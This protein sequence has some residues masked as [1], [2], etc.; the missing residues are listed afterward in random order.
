MRNAT[1]LVIIPLTIAAWLRYLLGISDTGHPMP[2]SPD[3]LYSELSSLLSHVRFGEPATGR[4]ALKDILSNPTI[5][6]V[7]LY[8]CQLA[9]KIATMF[10]E[11]L[12]G[13]GAVQATLRKY[14][15]LHAKDD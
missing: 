8:D 14:L 12:A 10:C 7:D 1:D 11:M 15:A 2:I 13:K 3:P 4:G 5:F 6:S 9:D